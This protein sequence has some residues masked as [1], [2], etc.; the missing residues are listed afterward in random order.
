[1]NEDITLVIADDHPIFRQ[2]LRQILERTAGLRVVAEAADGAEALA[3]LHALRPQIAVL[4][5]EMPLKDGFALAREVRDAALPIHIVFLTMYQEE[6]FF[7]AAL[8]LGV[9][10]YVLKDSAIAEIVTCLHN[11]AA[12]KPFVSPQMSGYL[13]KRIQG[14]VSDEPEEIQMLT[15]AERRVLKLLAAGKTSKQIAEDLGVSVRT[16]EHHRANAADKLDLKG[17]NALL[18]FAIQQQAVL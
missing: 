12:G 2:G 3:Q 8:D 4:D 15:V 9:K 17:G 13:I 6:R 5:V 14:N 1:M 16:I 11:V 7:N 18:Q 10:G